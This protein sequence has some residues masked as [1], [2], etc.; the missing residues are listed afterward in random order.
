MLCLV[1]RSGRL[2]FMSSEPAPVAANKPPLRVLALD[3]G[4]AKGFYTLGILD[5][6]E[7]NLR[8]P[9]EIEKKI[10]RPLSSRFD[11][12]F[13][14]STGA[15][16]AALLARG[17]SVENI[18]KLYKAHVP[19]IMKADNPG[20]RSAALRHLAT[21][22]FS[23]TQ[24]S[25]FKT[26]IGIV[27]TNWK[28]E[29]PFLFKASVAQAH[30]STGSFVPF[31]GCSVADAIT[32]SCS[33][34]PFFDTI[35]LDTTKGR[36]ELGDGGFCANNPTLYALTDAT[37]SL[38]YDKKNVR[39]VSLGVGAYP[40]PSFWKVIGRARGGWSMVRHGFNSDFLQKILDT[41]TGAMEQL[42]SLLFKDVPTIRINEGFP[43]PAMATD[44]L[45]H[46]M[47]KLERLL[48]KGR[49][50]YAKNEARLKELLLT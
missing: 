19:P 12:I 1:S 32:A 33:A 36:L 27:A 34:Y 22:V 7:K 42:A 40:P 4:G 13:G 23:T 44:L 26:R 46:N 31:F 38:A 3:G 11:L 25:D 39:M 29:K 15:I 50:S 48:H 9:E 41:N 49:E 14:T 10:S 28:E 20:K 6:L 16:I 37:V 18:I 47:E 24:V 35:T 45:E 21:E 8:T 2:L 43:E 30:G 17:D 5:E